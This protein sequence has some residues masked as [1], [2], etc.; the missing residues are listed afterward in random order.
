M[1]LPTLQA[2]VL[3][4]SFLRSFLMFAW[5]C[6]H[7]PSQGAQAGH[8]T[9]PSRNQILNGRRPWGKDCQEDA[10]KKAEMAERK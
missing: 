1:Q 5:L 3:N 6:H 8:S 4:F 9:I 2:A 10:E 7:V